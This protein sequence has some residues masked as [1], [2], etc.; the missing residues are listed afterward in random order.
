[1]NAKQWLQETAMDEK[2]TDSFDLS[3]AFP[4]RDEWEAK[5]A[6]AWFDMNVHGV[7]VE[8]RKH[9]ADHIQKQA[10]AFNVSSESAAAYTGRASSEMIKFAMDSR[11]RLSNNNEYKALADVP[12]PLEKMAQAIAELDMITGLNTQWDHQIPD[13]WRTVFTPSMEKRAEKEFK[14]SG[15]VITETDLRRLSEKAPRFV[16]SHLGLSRGS[17]FV[18]DP[19]SFF[20]QSSSEVQKVITQ[21]AKSVRVESR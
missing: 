17:R 15:E 4:I 20:E 18:H 10:S 14:C 2:V 3:E 19:V 16:E 11:A 9:L 13:P 5:Q 12:L 6:A 8:Y 21:M 7:P 1:M